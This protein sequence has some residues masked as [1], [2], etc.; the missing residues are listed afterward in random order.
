MKT[1]TMKSVTLNRIM[2]A[3]IIAGVIYFCIR[4]G[5]N[6]ANHWDYIKTTLH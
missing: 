3:V 1:L 4:A 5:V 2:A 6:I